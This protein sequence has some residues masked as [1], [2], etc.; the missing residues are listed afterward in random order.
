M[1]KN[2]KR[3]A[4]LLL[5]LAMLLT[6]T[7]CWGKKKDEGASSAPAAQVVTDS[8]AESAPD[9]GGEADQAPVDGSTEEAGAGFSEATGD[10]PSLD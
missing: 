5:A 10:G 7:A 6:L 1:R 9:A 8:A 3:L 4:V 2:W